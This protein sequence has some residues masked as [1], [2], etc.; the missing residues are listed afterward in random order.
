MVIN[1]SMQSVY[2]FCLLDCQ[3]ISVSQK[4]ERVR[5]KKRERERES[6]NRREWEEGEPKICHVTTIYL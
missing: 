4:K 5:E 3:A 2:I 6:E 1:E